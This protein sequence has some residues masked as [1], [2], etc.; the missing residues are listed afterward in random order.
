MRKFFSTAI[1]ALAMT[2]ASCGKNVESNERVATDSISDSV[3][4]AIVPQAATEV[5]PAA[6]PVPGLGKVAT[7]VIS[8]E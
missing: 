1:V 3:A 4:T 6:A 8:A 5:L 7:D 2:F